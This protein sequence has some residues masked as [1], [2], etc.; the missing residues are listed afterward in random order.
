VIDPLL[1]RFARALVPRALGSTK[2]KM[3]TGR[4]RRSDAG[5]DGEAF[6]M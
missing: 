3:V 4:F 2:L 1:R 6:R 5:Q